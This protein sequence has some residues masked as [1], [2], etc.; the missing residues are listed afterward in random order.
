MMY[1]ICVDG[2]ERERMLC[3][4]MEIFGVVDLWWPQWWI[5]SRAVLSSV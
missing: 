2:T 4:D 3:A 1:L 5:E